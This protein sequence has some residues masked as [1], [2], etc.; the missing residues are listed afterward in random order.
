MS[1]SV[2][3]VVIVGSAG[4]LDLVFIDQQAC[5]KMAIRQLIHIPDD[6]VTYCV[7]AYCTTG[8]CLL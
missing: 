7:I 2:V 5:A 3:V 6:D 1:L 8:L 4:A